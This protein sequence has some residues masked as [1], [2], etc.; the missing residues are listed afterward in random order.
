MA[1]EWKYSYEIKQF[2]NGTFS[3]II[4]LYHE[5]GFPGL[6]GRSGKS[7]YARQSTERC[8]QTCELLPFMTKDYRPTSDSIQR[9][10]QFKV[11][12]AELEIG[13]YV[14]K[15]DRPWLESLF[16]FQGF[17]LETL[18]DIYEVQEVCE[19]VYI[20][21]IEKTSRST[22]G[23]GNTNNKAQRIQKVT[24]KSELPKAREI[25][26]KAREDVGLILKGIKYG[27]EIDLEQTSSVV[28]QCVDSILRNEQAMVCLSQLEKTDQLL[29]EHSL[30]SCIISIS[31]GK[32]LNMLDFELENL[33][34]CALLHD[35]GQVKIPEKVLKKKSPLSTEEVKLLQKHTEYGRQMLMSLSSIHPGVVDMA[36]S[37][38]E[39]IDGKGYPR[40]IKG[41]KIPHFAKIIAIADAYTD[42][43]MGHP[44]R[45]PKTSLEALRILFEF[46][47]RQYES[48]LV[49]D[50]IQLMG[51][52]PPGNIVE[53]TDGEVGIILSADSRYK[54]RPEVL[55]ILDQF[56]QPQPPQ[57]VDLKTLALDFFGKP[58]VVKAIHPNGAY[59]IDVNDFEVDI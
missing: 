48:E 39:R 31:F 44:R 59:G 16:L 37:H 29:A 54:L 25:Y 55:L 49:I 33:G 43:T 4:R 23:S 57:A 15:L 41:D 14:S 28:K 21:V 13:M 50:F 1:N 52:Y 45:Q 27:Q 38:H 11:P 42:M 58:Y 51:V 32:H 12:V 24:V 47:N 7:L 5:P 53:M 19:Y 6:T 46:R 36:Y 2:E 17:L 3:K 30:C 18:D 34:L 56:K 40:G 9:S 26:S 35:I 22:S 20:D 8:G 10:H